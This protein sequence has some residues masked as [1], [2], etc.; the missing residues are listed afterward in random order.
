MLN[1]SPP[2][3]LRYNLRSRLS[4]IHNDDEKNL[5]ALSTLVSLPQPRL[6]RMSRQARGE[7]RFDGGINSTFLGLQE[8]STLTLVEGGSGSNAKQIAK[9]PHSQ[10]LSNSRMESR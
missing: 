1:I 6:E 2:A 10:R 7:G 5:I 4:A 9:T 8:S 3:L